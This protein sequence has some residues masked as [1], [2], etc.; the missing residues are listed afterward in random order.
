MLHAEDFIWCPRGDPTDAKPRAVPRLLD[1]ILAAPL[2]EAVGEGRIRPADE[3]EVL[4]AEEHAAVQADQR[5]P[6]GF[7]TVPAEPHDG[8]RPAP[9]MS[10]RGRIRVLAR[11]GRRE[12]R[13]H[14][15]SQWKRGV[16]APEHVGTRTDRHHDRASSAEHPCG[17]RFRSR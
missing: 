9:K 16:N 5:Q 1:H 3:R 13:F 11:R 7:A 6:L 12:V 2:D 8:R 4:G 15:L 17:P 10:D 14:D